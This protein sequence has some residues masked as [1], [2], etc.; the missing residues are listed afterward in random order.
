MSKMSKMTISETIIA[1]ATTRLIAEAT[2]K[3]IAKAS[4]KIIAEATPR[5]IAKATPKI[6]AEAKRQII[7]EVKLKLAKEIIFKLLAE[8]YDLTKINQNLLKKIETLSDINIV[9][10]IFFVALNTTSIKDFTKYSKYL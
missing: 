2:P 6:I 8:K 1:E 7:T 3:F 5:I 9:N 10:N 4:P